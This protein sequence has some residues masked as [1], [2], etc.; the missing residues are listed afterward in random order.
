MADIAISNLPNQIEEAAIGD[1]LAIDDISAGET[2]KI[3]FESL[4]GGNIGINP[5]FSTWQENT[6]FTNPADN[7]YT[8]DGYLVGSGAGGG[9]LPTINVKKNTT[10]MEVGFEQ[11][12]ELE[13]TN[14]GGAGATRS[15]RHEQVIEDY[16]KYRGKTVTFAIRVKASTA[17]TLSA[18]NLLLFDGVGSGTMALTSVTTSWAT[19]SVTMTIVDAATRLEIRFQ[20]IP[21]G[22]GTISTTGSIY[23]QF[24][25]L[26][27]GSVA[28]PL[29]PRKT[30]DEL[31]L[32]QRYYQKSYS[33]TVFAGAA[34]EVGATY[35]ESSAHNEA[36]HT[37][38]HSERLPVSMKAAPT[39]TLYDNA[40]N[41]GKVT[42]AAG[43][44]I[45]GL[46][47]AIT[48]SNFRITGTNGVVNT[49]RILIF[50]YT[51]ISRV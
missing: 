5:T 36:D 19:Y 13:I 25:K 11:C 22:T 35:I 15:W 20:L 43:N 26:E 14:V 16:K 38:R 7:V 4:Q 21:T 9:T 41:S 6:T 10:D 33:Q 27:L 42:M 1:M 31:A 23:I 47:A 51:A 39:V 32:C 49:S 37:I 24:M 17:I 18:G 50:Q 2:K 34:T 45:A 3:P 40:G 12:C 46:V 48:D 44:N 29:I 30:G 28:T 8:A